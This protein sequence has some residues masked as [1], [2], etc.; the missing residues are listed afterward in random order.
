MDGG[1]GPGAGSALDAAVSRILSSLA[2]RRAAAS[3]LLHRGAG[4]FS[5]LFSSLSCIFVCNSCLSTRTFFGLALSASSFSNRMA[6][7]REGSS[8]LISSLILTFCQFGFAF[9]VGAA[10]GCGLL[11]VRNP[12]NPDTPSRMASAK[13]ECVMSQSLQCLEHGLPQCL[14]D[15]KSIISIIL[16]WP[17]NH[18]FVN[19]ANCTCCSLHHNPATVSVT[20]IC[21][22]PEQIGQQTSASCK[23]RLLGCQ[24]A[25][26]G[27]R[28]KVSRNGAL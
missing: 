11:R 24:Q 23:S 21:L 3:L 7:V 18:L 8:S 9:G 15:W 1:R 25:L 14:A 20:P 26:K 27:T 16:L 19:R 22:K 12:L 6:A 5:F 13:S 2:S 17:L 28:H 4:N 10:F